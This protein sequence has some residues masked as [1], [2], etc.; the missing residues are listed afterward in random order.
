MLRD[1]IGKSLLTFVT[2]LLLRTALGLTAD[3]LPYC[4]LWHRRGFIG[5]VLLWLGG[6][7]CGRW[8]WTKEVEAIWTSVLDIKGIGGPGVAS[9]EVGWRI[10]ILKLIISIKWDGDSRG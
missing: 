7:R 9:Q 6:C 3:I 2:N 1:R 4:R 10:R 5:V 8:V